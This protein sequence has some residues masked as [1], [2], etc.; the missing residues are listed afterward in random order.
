MNDTTP[1][2]NKPR[3]YS[4]IR[5]LVLA[6]VR[7]FYRQP[8]AVFWVYGFPIIMVVALG[9]AFRNQPV[10]KVSVDVRAGADANVVLERLK[11][12]DQFKVA[13][14]DEETCLRRLRTGKTD[15]VIFVDSAEYKYHFDP[16][17]PGSQVARSRVDDFLQRAAGR[18]DVVEVADVERS[19][20]GGRY[21]DFLVPGLLGMGLLGGGLWGVGFVTVD[22][23][24]RQLLKRFCATPMKRSHFLASLMISRLI[25]MVPE[26]LL[27]L[28]FS[29]LVFGVVIH[30]SIV[31]VIVLILLG[32]VMFAGIGLLVAS[33]AKTLEAVSGLMNLVMLPM[34]VLSGIFF[35]SDR[36]PDVMQPFIK[37]LPLTPLIDSLRQVML[38]GATLA[39]LT[40]QIAIMA[41]WALGCF[42][43]ALKW[44]R[45]S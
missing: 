37:L 16:T 18:E 11:N 1:K 45:W 25:F 42:L 17:R 39:S 9:L 12:N 10:E 21:I 38:E 6:R 31:A 19:D 20:P 30:G 27:L 36:F 22:L 2:Q 35:S 23:R 4:P 41:A 40:T 15:L 44:F 26:I 3:S 13:V 8:E 43:L 14:H 28:L 29:W 24:I 33:R 7:E 34:W 5:E 32:A